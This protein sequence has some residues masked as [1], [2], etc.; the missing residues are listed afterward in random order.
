MEV[1]AAEVR[2]LVASS[3]DGPV[4]SVYLNTDGARYPSPSEYLARLDGLLRDVKRAAES[5]E[6][7][8]REKVHADATEI[9]RWVRDEFDRGD[10]RGLALFASDG[11]VFERVQSA[12]AVRNVARVGDVAYVVPLQVLLGRRHLVALAV[13]QRDEARIFRYS[14]GR[15]EE[16]RDLSSDV[17]RQHAQGGWS[18][19]RFER[20]IEHEVLHHMKEAADAL[21]RGHEEEP[22]D[23]VVV[24]GTRV[25][26]MEFT[27]HLHPYVKERVHGEPMSLALSA[28]ADEI[29]DRL[30]E[31]E[32]HLVSER[33]SELLQRLMASRGVA[34]S[35]AFGPRAVVDAANRRA[36]ET[37]FVVEG[38]GV[39]G[40]KSDTGALALSQEA[41][42]AFGQ[43]AAP[44]DDIV[45][46][47]IEVAVLGGSQIE[48]FRDGSR[49]DGH[50]MAA[51]LRY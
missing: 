28:G 35:G 48:M 49:L 1:N 33:R 42:E 16:Y 47:L 17:H 45:D 34:E 39:R 11:S 13:V 36:I 3:E 4:T 31:V 2:R 27:K 41:A 50:D 29:R 37:L 24:A 21:L 10:T 32:Q 7:A 46:E 44:V 18:Q 25:E 43:S 20:N 23:A 9:K 6:P 5:R 22:F 19:A 12:V 14:L 30:R 40:Y 8:E 38:S 51:L 15:L 26:A